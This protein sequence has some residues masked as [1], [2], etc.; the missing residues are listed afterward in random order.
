MSYFVVAKCHSF[1]NHLIFVRQNC[2]VFLFLSLLFHCYFWL[3][4]ARLLA[5][6]SPTICHH[7]AQKDQHRP[8]ACLFSQ[9]RSTSTRGPRDCFP[10][11]LA[12]SH[13]A[14]KTN[15]TAKQAKASFPLVQATLPFPQDPATQIQANQARWPIGRQAR[16]LGMQ[17]ACPREVDRSLMQV[18]SRALANVNSSPISFTLSASLSSRF[19]ADPSLSSVPSSH[20]TLSHPQPYSRQLH[21]RLLPTAHSLRVAP[22]KLLTCSLG[23]QT[24]NRFHWCTHPMDAQDRL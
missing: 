2:L 24:A 3:G 21:H 10:F 17:R 12:R 8:T 13:Y 7:M 20:P 14:V 4:K 23:Y 22:I 15:C 1:N 11:Y 19:S 5:H 6:F 18:S 9:E 16:T